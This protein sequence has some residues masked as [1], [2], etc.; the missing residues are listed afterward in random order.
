MLAFSA[1][2][3]YGMNMKESK[4]EE[5][6][7]AGLKHK[8]R[9][10]TAL[11][12]RHWAQWEV[13]EQF[14]H[15][16][17]QSITFYGGKFHLKGDAFDTMERVRAHC[18]T[19]PFS[20][21]ETFN[22]LADSDTIVLNYQIKTQDE[23]WNTDWNVY[24][25][26]VNRTVTHT[27]ITCQNRARKQQPVFTD[28]G[29]ELYYL[30]MGIPQAE[31]DKSNLVVMDLKT[32]QSKT[33]LSTW[34]LSPDQFVV[35]KKQVYLIAS[36]RGTM[37]LFTLSLDSVANTPKEIPFQHGA[38]QQI[39]GIVGDDVY[40]VSSDWN[41]PAEV[42]KMNS[43]ASTQ[44]THLNGKFLSQIDD[45]IVEEMWIKTSDGL[46]VQGWILYP[47][48]LDRSKKTPAVLTLH[49]GPQGAWNNVWSYRWPAAV[50]AAY[51]YPIILVNPRGSSGYGIEFQRAVTGDW[52]GKPMDDDLEFL[53]AT[54]EKFSFIDGSAIGVMGASYGGFSTNW[55]VHTGRF[56]AAVSHDGL[57]DFKSFYYTTDEVFFA[58]MEFGG[59]P[60]DEP[61]PESYEKCS[62]INY[63]EQ[64][65][66]P[67]LLIHG[68][69]DFRIDW[70]QNMML[71]T[72]LQRR[73]IPSKLVLFDRASHWVTNVNDWLYWMEIIFD[74][75]EGWFAKYL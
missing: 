35:T 54:I 71:F 41:R 20:G 46:E 36:D 65:E 21:S 10:F 74:Q 27:C 70:T 12:F 57:V 60:Y 50:F 29:R 61:L 68:Q 39:V 38:V 26:K 6:R 19:R 51:G 16:F 69:Q 48:N 67:M 2:V 64:I 53:D 44:V 33:F 63:I 58:E 59:K 31:S 8:V 47:H 62:P 5:D 3:F 43:N 15:V 1:T 34:H 32:Q 72:G 40:V 24:F 13:E 25:A 37:K 56:K 18:P 9:E 11:K 14:D 75:K 73:G 52:C 30:T 45:T 42:Y 55:L 49:G 4:K 17:T 7:R 28:D 23:A 22:F 66:A